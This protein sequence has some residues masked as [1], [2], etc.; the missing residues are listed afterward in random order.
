MLR[1][2]FILLAMQAVG[3][4]ITRSA[5]IPIPGNV[6]GMGLLLAALLAG[7]VK[8]EWID[9]AADLLLAYMALFFVPA[10]VGVMVYFD[11]IEREWLAISVAMIL[12]TFVVMFVTGRVEQWL[13]KEA[14]DAE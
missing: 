12:S 14:G 3:E 13:G 4:I 10:G 9:Q 7:W 6:V 2:M 8:L 1:G 5:D 11:L